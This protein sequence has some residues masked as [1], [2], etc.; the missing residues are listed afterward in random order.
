MFELVQAFVA[1]FYQVLTPTTFGVMLVGIAVGFVVGILPGLGGPTTLA[2]MLPFIF[3]MSAVEAFAFL[4]GMSAVTAT[5]GDI[6][7]ILFGVPGEPTTAS[8]V[9]DGHPM[10]KKGEAGRA[11]G[12]ALMSSLV[13]AIFGAFFLAAAVPIVRPLVLTFGSPE[14][15]MIALL[16]V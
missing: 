4:L 2:L 6:T 10:A 16:G 12:A 13:G 7:S 14:F 5:T 8:T 3:K 1:G 15:F 9:V 11:L